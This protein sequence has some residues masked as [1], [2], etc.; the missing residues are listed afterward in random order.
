M[1]NEGSVVVTAFP[2]GAKA[3]V[4][5][6]GGISVA[7][8]IEQAGFATRN[9]SVRVNG[10]ESNRDACVRHGDRIALTEQIK[11]N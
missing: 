9:W 1:A 8:A 3:V 6:E 2:G 5:P 4:V 11:G 7:A 10:V